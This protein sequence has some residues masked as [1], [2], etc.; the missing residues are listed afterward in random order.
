[1]KLLIIYKNRHTGNW[2]VWS[3]LKTFK[4][5]DFENYRWLSLNIMEI[6]SNYQ[7]NKRVVTKESAR[8]DYNINF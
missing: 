3:L 8:E 1:M 6:N 4:I 5:W 2:E 7:G